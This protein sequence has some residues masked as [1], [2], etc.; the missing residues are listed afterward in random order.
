M[1]SWKLFDYITG[2]GDNLLQNWYE[3]QE[4]EVQAQ[5]DAT[6]FILKAT[7]DWDSD[8]VK[9]FKPLTKNHIGLGEVI[10]HLSYA[11]S[12][13]RALALLGWCLPVSE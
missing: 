8:D 13:L 2:D 7:Q 4:P 1:D 3:I 12:G 9:E 10:F 5:F 11:R 6:L